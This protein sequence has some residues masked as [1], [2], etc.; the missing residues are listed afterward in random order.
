M[1]EI[2]LSRAVVIVI[3]WLK[4]DLS[5]IGSQPSGSGKVLFN[6]SQNGKTG[7]DFGHSHLGQCGVL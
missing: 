3:F 5:E 7:T 4:T 6:N 2:I 1:F